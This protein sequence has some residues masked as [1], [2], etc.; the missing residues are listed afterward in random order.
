AKQP[1]FMWNINPEF[2]GHP[3][4]FANEGALCF[5]CAGHGAPYLAKQLNVTKVGVLAY[6]IAAQSKDCAAGLRNSFVKYPA[7]QV[8]FF[9]D[10]LQYAQPL[11]AQVTQMKQKGVGLVFTCVDL[12]ESFTLAKEMNKQGMKAVQSLP[13]GYDQ[14]FV[15]S[16][17]SVLEGSVVA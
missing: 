6:G 11:G 8:A 15:S 10:S 16:N 12:Q 7:G 4:F 9:D 2:A 5:T 1:V 17:A 14:N 13:N 3:T